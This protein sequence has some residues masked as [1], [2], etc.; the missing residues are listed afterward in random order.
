MASAGGEHKTVWR[1]HR[2][3][4]LLTT[5]SIERATVC[6]YL[7]SLSANWLF[8]LICPHRRASQDGLAV[9]MNPRHQLEELH[10]QRIVVA[11]VHLTDERR[12]TNDGGVERLPLPS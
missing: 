1:R 11:N 5:F 4:H 2:F 3:R 6:L 8:C 7:S 9:V 12:L 10:L